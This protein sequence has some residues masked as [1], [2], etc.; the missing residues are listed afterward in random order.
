MPEHR[1][2]HMMQSTY[3]GGT[4]HAALR[5]M[6]DLCAAG[7]E[8][9][10]TSPR[11]RG[12]SWPTVLT[13]DPNAKAF[14]CRGRGLLG[15]FDPAQFWRLREHVLQEARRCQAIW[16]S[17]SSASSLLASRGT[18][19]PRLMS[20]HYHHFEGRLSWIRWK[21]FYETLCRDLDAIT[22]P[23]EFTRAEAIRVAPWLSSRARVVPYG[24]DVGFSDENDRRA[25]QS[26]ARREL[27]LPA[28]AVIV[29][30]GGWL[31][32]RKRFDV[33]LRTAAKICATR[34]DV[35]FVVCGGGPLAEDLK[36]LASS[37]GISARVRFTGWV[38]DMRPYYR[39][40][41]MILFNSDHDT[42]PRAPMEAASDGCVV[43]ASLL[44]GGLGEF[45]VHR[46]NGY[47]FDRHCPDT[48]AAAVLELAADPGHVARLRR[49][50]AADLRKRF[51]SE[52][53]LAFYRHF[54][55]L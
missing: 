6:K 48:L 45:L 47:L 35:Y 32:P 29:G 43:V 27:D 36:L 44:Y 19:R 23:T 25:Q 15:K 31:I 39:A 55:G 38:A 33:F 52:H 34:S 37:L 41:D 30:N 42:L 3:L 4:E 11:P 9:A 16:I 26:A 2:L 14:P 1:I 28:D 54:F 20:H 49:E 40:W 53:G 22:F 8:F 21:V 5:V 18:R 13:F 51:S 7:V 10:V 12:Q 46:H 17:G 24:Y 50:A